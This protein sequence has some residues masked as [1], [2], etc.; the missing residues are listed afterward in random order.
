MSI[1]PETSKVLRDQGIISVKVLESLEKN[2]LDSGKSVG[3][4]VELLNNELENSKKPIKV[5]PD[6][7][8]HV[9]EES[10]E[11]FKKILVSKNKKGWSFRLLVHSPSPN[12]YSYGME[13]EKKPAKEDIVVKKHDLKFFVSKKHLKEIQGTKIDFDKKENGFKFSKG[14]NG[15]K[16][17]RKKLKLVEK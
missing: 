11:E 14:K 15:E 4:I 5:D 7:V 17:S 6:S 9:S 8:L 13:I 1:F 10:A 2:I 16:W 12:V 3:E